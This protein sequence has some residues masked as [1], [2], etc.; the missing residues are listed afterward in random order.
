M[1][2]SLYF[3]THT[4]VGLHEEVHEERNDGNYDDDY[5]NVDTA[6]ESHTPSQSLSTSSTGSKRKKSDSS[7]LCATLTK[8]IASRGKSDNENTTK[9]KQLAVFF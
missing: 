3:R 4:N 6:S 1:V 7:Y 9:K 8:F 5:D 2:S